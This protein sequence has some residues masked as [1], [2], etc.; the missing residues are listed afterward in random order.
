MKTNDPVI[1]LYIGRKVM[2]LVFILER[3]LMKMET[4]LRLKVTVGESLG[5]SKKAEFSVF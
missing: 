4:L 5:P 3:L 1:V 2:L